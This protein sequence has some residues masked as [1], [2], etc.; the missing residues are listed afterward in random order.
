M[1]KWH[2]GTVIIGAEGSFF[3][4]PLG[5][6]M[7]GFVESQRLGSQCWRASGGHQQS[8]NLPLQMICY[9]CCDFGIFPPICNGCLGFS[10][11]QSVMGIVDM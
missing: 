1:V 11:C 6:Q 2:G 10:Y 7:L 9:G 4:D 5:G 3:S 8:A